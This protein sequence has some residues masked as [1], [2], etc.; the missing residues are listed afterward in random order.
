MTTVRCLVS[1]NHVDVYGYLNN[2]HYSTYFEKGRLAIQDALGIPDALLI[3]NDVGLWVVDAT[4]TYLRP[5]EVYQ[6]IMIESRVRKEDMTVII[7]HQMLNKGKV[8]ASAAVNHAFVDL[9]TR[10]PLRPLES[11]VRQLEGQGQMSV[12]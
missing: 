7:N 3:R 10:K 12:H 6:E 8:I 5:V 11:V 9:R 4:Y 2:G 1:P